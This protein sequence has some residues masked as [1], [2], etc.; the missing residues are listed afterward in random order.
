MLTDLIRGDVI[1]IIG[2]SARS[3]PRISRES[4]RFE[5]SNSDDVQVTLLYGSFFLFEEEFLR[6]Y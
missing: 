3:L 2:R 4:V 1:R 5:I 6:L